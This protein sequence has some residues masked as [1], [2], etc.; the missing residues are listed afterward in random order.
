MKGLGTCDGADLGSGISLQLPRGAGYVSFDVAKY[1]P[2]VCFGPD[3]N[4][5]AAAQAPADSVGDETLQNLALRVLAADHSFSGLSADDV[6]RA[7][8]LSLGA[9][10]LAL[11]CLVQHGRAFNTISH[12]R[13]AAV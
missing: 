5:L 8:G 3:G 12:E 10:R 7:L 1:E 2:E 6:S 9:V 13:F 11:E 4:L